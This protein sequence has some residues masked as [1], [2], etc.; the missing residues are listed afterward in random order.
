LQDL[1]LLHQQR[2]RGNQTGVRSVKDLI[3]EQHAPYTQITTSAKIPTVGANPLELAGKSTKYPKMELQPLKFVKMKLK[4]MATTRRMIDLMAMLMKSTKKMMKTMKMVPKFPKIQ[5][6]R[7][8]IS[9]LLSPPSEKL[10]VEVAN[11]L[12]MLR[13]LHSWAM[14][15]EQFCLRVLFLC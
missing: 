2:N 6:L 10:V 15:H 12:K 1:L 8:S 14:D 4:M 9:I 3:I 13:S 7:S 5:I 11:M